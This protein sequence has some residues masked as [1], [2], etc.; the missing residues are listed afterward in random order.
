MDKYY[1]VCQILNE[2]HILRQ[3]HLSPEEVD[4]RK[5]MIRRMAALGMA[6]GAGVT[7]AE[8]MLN[9]EARHGILA[10]MG[11]KK[12]A[13]KLIDKMAKEKEA[14]AS[15]VPKTLGQKVWGVTKRVTPPMAVG[16]GLDLAIEPANVHIAQG[17]E[18]R[19][20]KKKQEEKQ[21]QLELQNQQQKV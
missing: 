19:L 3:H 18:D 20:Q 9:P 16:A 15:G 11:N 2:A 13:Q 6:A 5:R 12:A 10:A 21:K 1:Q 4:R 14:L 17:M 8:L 7:A